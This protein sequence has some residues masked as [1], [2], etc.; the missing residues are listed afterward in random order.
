[1]TPTKKGQRREPVA[2]AAEFVSE[3]IGWL[4]FVAPPWFGV[5]ILPMNSFCASLAGAKP[6]SAACLIQRYASANCA[7]VTRPSSSYEIVSKYRLPI[8]GTA[9]R[10]GTRSIPLVKRLAR[11]RE[12]PCRHC[13]CG[14]PWAAA[15]D[16]SREAGTRPQYERSLGLCPRGT[17]RLTPRTRATS[18][19]QTKAT[20]MRFVFIVLPNV[21]LTDRRASVTRES[22]T[23]VLGGGSV[24]RRVRCPCFWFPNNQTENQF[25]Q[26]SS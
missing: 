5:P 24:K 13:A 16:Q 25:L 6:L 1:M 17:D 10:T 22:P 21:G 26:E 20:M 3:G 19:R 12:S 7:G 11:T 15:K 18:S 14:S 2:A 23:D 8:I 9:D 4:P